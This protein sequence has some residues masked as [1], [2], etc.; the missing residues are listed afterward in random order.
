ME[1]GRD[2]G[3][4][5]SLKTPA[6]TPASSNAGNKKREAPLHDRLIGVSDSHKP[7]LS[8][9]AQLAMD[10]ILFMQRP[11]H[12]RSRAAAEFNRIAIRVQGMECGDRLVETVCALAGRED[13]ERPEKALGIL[14]LMAESL[15][16]E[17][18]GLSCKIADVVGLM[19]RNSPDEETMLLSLKV[20]NALTLQKS[21]GAD[22]LS[23]LEDACSVR[24]EGAE[25]MERLKGIL[26]GILA[27]A[28]ELSPKGDAELPARSIPLG[29]TL[30]EIQLL[31]PQVKSAR[32][33]DKPHSRP[34]LPNSQG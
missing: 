3:N 16:P 28:I 15:K 2:M 21:F 30:K 32:V 13:I 14:R 26:R 25:Q 22:I 7:V 11:E 18:S 19:V 1:A 33:P 20:L 6:Q 12:V 4:I 31:L 5:S 23:N 8:S 29:L 10:K 9:G 34:S 27:T 24:P 17:H